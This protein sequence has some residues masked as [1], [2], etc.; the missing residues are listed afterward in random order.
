[1]FNLNDLRNTL[2]RLAAGT[3]TDAD[4]HALQEAL[5]N[6]QI[7]LAT[8]KRAVAIGGDMDDVI[9]ISGN[10]NIVFK[11]K[12]ADSIRQILSI[13]PVPRLGSPP[14]IPNII[15]GRENALTHLKQRLGIITS[16]KG[17]ASTQIITTIRGWPG[18][19]KTTLVTAIAHDKEVIEAF[20]DGILWTSLG[21]KPNLL[22]EV[23]IW[24]RALGT[25]NLLRTPTLKEAITQ[26]SAL[27]QKRR[28][29]LLVDDVW[30]AEHAAP[31]QKARGNEC[32]LL[33]TTRE[34]VV[35]NV[36]APTADAVYNLSVLTEKS[37]LKLLRVLAP[38]VVNKYQKECLQLVRNLECLPLALQVAGHMLNVEASM[39]WG[40]T[41]LLGELQEIT[42]LLKEKAPIEHT[43]LETQTT[44][45]VAA[46]LK[47]SI[48]RLDVQTREYFA[49]LGA[50][51]PKPATFDLTA[52]KAVW[53]VD[54]AKPI[55]RRLVERGLIEPVGGRFQ[56][57]ALLAAH[58]RLLCEE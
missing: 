56:M 40:V 33:I 53:M 38:S 31:F 22:S 54:D 41:E 15:I 50:F 57:H 47:K 32:A 27:L 55:A 19:G 1:M 25:D 48:D 9:F 13:N 39:G 36:L 5:H 6:K 30:E 43:E 28:M 23:A 51:A 10:N 14:P 45:T 52:M 35:A 8:G 29:L 24:G 4:Q 20:P 26:L 37:A 18:V 17:S 2:E 21:K 11:D 16:R 58:A 44:P 7:F 42:R 46:L 49:Y 3:G 12:D 34:P